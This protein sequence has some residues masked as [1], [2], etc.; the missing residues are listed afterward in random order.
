MSGRKGF[1]PWVALFVIYVVWG[2]TYMAI[3][4]AV[5]EMPPMAAAALRFLVAGVLMAGVAFVVDRRHGRP[6]GRQLLDYSLVGFLL[7]AVGNALVMW[8]EQRIPSG[9]A[10][11]IVATVPL[12]LTLFDG[13]RAAGQPWT[14]RA[15]IGTVVGLFG[16][17]ILA[18]PE[19]SLNA[20]HWPAVIGLQVATLA[21][22]TGTLYAQS[23]PRRLP[24]FSA[25]AVEMVAGG[26][27]LVVQ[28]L[29][30]GESW[31]AFRT[32][33]WEAWLSILYLVVFGSLIGFTAFAYC[34]NELP[35]PVVGT[36]AYVNP[37]VAVALGA[38]FLQERVSESLIAGG[39]LVLVSVVITTLSRRQP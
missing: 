20:G 26:L 24:L 36:Y 16:V 39:L 31:A 9:V 15:W 6:T 4:V 38:L 27:A 29:L 30:L 17:F 34:I 14:V 19:G 5:K 32:A 7:L 33:S 12:W 35:A 10:A 37:V 25:A 11:L 13:F 18:R 2:S 8:A 21:W 22:A 3:A 1:W 23:V 28:S